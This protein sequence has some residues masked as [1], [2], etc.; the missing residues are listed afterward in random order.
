MLDVCIDIMI[1][2]AHCNKASHPQGIQAL[3]AKFQKNIFME[4]HMC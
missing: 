2:S 3:D 4:H 1:E